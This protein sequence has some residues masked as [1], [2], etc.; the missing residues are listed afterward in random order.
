MST[1][2]RHCACSIVAVVCTT[3]ILA[4]PAAQAQ[5]SAPPAKAVAP[6]AAAPP[7]PTF[8]SP[9][10]AAPSPALPK[11]VGEGAPDKVDGKVPKAATV[12]ETAPAVTPPVPAP[13]TEAPTLSAPAP[14]PVVVPPTRYFVLIFG[15]ESVPKR[16][17]FTHTFMTVVKATPKASYEGVYDPASGN[18]IKFY[19]LTAHTI[20]WMPASMRIRVIKFRPECGVNLDLHTSLRYC[21]GM[22]EKLALYGPYELNPTIAEEVYNKTLKQIAKLKSGR[23]LYKSLDPDSGPQLGWVVDCI[24]AVSDLDG[25]QRRAKYLETQHFGWDGS[26]VIVQSLVGANRVDPTTRHAWVADAL[27]LNCYRLCVL[28][29]RTCRPPTTIPTVAPMTASR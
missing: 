5:P 25:P 9:E 4:N 19:D 22:C 28:N 18:Q 6:A 3:L 26:T 17:R 12:K 11:T 20:S 7:K 15:A 1:F 2:V 14:N 10:N 8:V 16:G 24:H 13:P 27:N 23:V 21:S 29:M